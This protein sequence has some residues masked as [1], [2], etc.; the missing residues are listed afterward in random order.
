MESDSDTFYLFNLK[1]P[2][3][4][5][6]KQ[7]GHLEACDDLHQPPARDGRGGGLRPR[8]RLRDQ[9]ER[10][11]GRGEAGTQEIMALHPP[12]P[13]SSVKLQAQV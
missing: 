1:G 9:G 8:R 10:E 13:S 11:Q 4:H 2:S 7:A 12:R 6:A 3:R 5:Q